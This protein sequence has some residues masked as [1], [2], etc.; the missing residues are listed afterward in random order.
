[1]DRE[2]TQENIR[3]E[4][5]YLAW[6][7]ILEMV[8]ET[9]VWM[10]D[11]AM[12]GRLTASALSAVGLGGQLMYT[13]LNIFSAVGVG[14]SAMVA[15]YCGGGEYDRAEH[16]VGQSFLLS[17]I[18]GSIMFVTLYSIIPTFFNKLITQT[19]IAAQGIIYTRIIAVGGSIMVPTKVLNYALRG[20]GNTRVPMLSTLIA[21]LFNIFG[22]YALIFGKF[23]MPRMGVAGAAIATS[24]SQ[25]L[26]L[27]VSAGYLIFNKNG[28]K[29][30]FADI[31]NID[32]GI[33]KKLISLGVPASLYEFSDNGSRLISSLW[34]SRMGSIAFAAQ[35][36]SVSAESM[37]FM[38]G[39]G[40]SVSAA[41]M[42]GQA[43]GAG[44]EEKAEASTKESSKMA[45]IFMSIIG[46]IFFI[47][48]GRLMS[49]FTN[50]AGVRNLSAKC[51]RI[52]AFE[53][54]TMALSMALSGALKGAGDTKG[55]FYVTMISTW[56]IRLPLIFMSVFVWK[57]S[58]E[59]VWIIT[60]LQFLAEA[61]LMAF[62]FKKGVWKKIK[63]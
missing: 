11:T 43:L 57:L 20:S 41:T 46:L 37:S 33:I 7:A 47:I 12:V 39:V 3:T 48:P 8:L 15:R 27:C 32:S 22:D 42:V 58:I 52:A 24:I 56:M 34:L 14:C 1:M 53:Q 5:F 26:S 63:L 17:I 50:I 9:S 30:K 35:Q 44:N 61:L 59:Y 60:D 36:V 55:P 38:P 4:I 54:P 23:G 25:A 16:V 13:M 31:R 29:L 28:I 49:F 6:P 62:R 19:D 10:F 51:I 18:I 40:F 2:N 45:V 21:D